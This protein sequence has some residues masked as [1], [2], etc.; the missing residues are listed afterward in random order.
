MIECR[1][2][3]FAAATLHL[4]SLRARSPSMHPP[5]SP[6]QVAALVLKRLLA[7]AA[8]P[9]SS[10]E[11]AAVVTQPP[12]P[13]GRGNRKVPQPSPVAVA[14]AEAGLPPD[15]VLSPERPGEAGFLAALRQL[16][17][18][19]CV[20]AAYGNYLP[21]SFLGLPPHGTL[22]IHPSL[23]P[24]YRG[25]A[26]VQRA[27]QDGLAVSGV[28]VL[29]TVKAMDAGPILAQQKLAVRWAGRAWR[30]LL[31]RG[32]AGSG[33]HP[34]HG[35]G[36]PTALLRFHP[37]TFL[38]HPIPMLYITLALSNRWTPISRRRSC[39]TPCLSWAPTC[40]WPTWTLCGRGWGSWRRSPRCGSRRCGDHSGEGW[41]WPASRWLAVGGLAGAVS[42][43]IPRAALTAAARCTAQDEAAATHAPKLSREEAVLDFSQSA[44]ACHN[45]VRAF[46]GWP[47][48]FATFQ[49]TSEDGA[50]SEP[51][52]LKI[53]RTRLAEAGAWPAGVGERQVAATKDALLVRCGDGGVLQVRRGRLAGW[54]CGAALD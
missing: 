39:W 52:E 23:L 25:A 54:V 48:T 5:S 22:N 34:L 10:F 38:G 8:A 32:C 19:L 31:S 43:P 6:A 42:L 3:P 46:A 28:T 9:D 20:T 53:V 11:V 18:D 50:S 1:P 14:A 30:L 12:R 33:G 13:T 16:S 15:L 47:S 36:S 29:Y 35:A 26:P 49:A 51:L 7:A 24:A 45:K 17:P 37:T 21:S 27:L 40:W 44:A 4:V 41:W 2:P